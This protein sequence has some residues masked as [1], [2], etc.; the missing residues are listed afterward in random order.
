MS[1]GVTKRFGRCR[2]ALQTVAAG[3]SAKY[4][5]DSQSLQRPL[6]AENLCMDRSQGLAGVHQ[7]WDPRTHGT[8][9]QQRRPPQRPDNTGPS[10]AGR[11]SND[12]Q[13]AGRAT[14]TTTGTAREPT[15]RTSRA[16]AQTPQPTPWNQRVKGGQKNHPLPCIWGGGGG[17]A[18]FQCSKKCRRLWPQSSQ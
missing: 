1:A 2:Q 18:H 13:H 14:H 10:Q 9:E 7:V 3:G 16:A 15:A 8:K 11:P 17:I 4:A 5:H 6:R 12:G